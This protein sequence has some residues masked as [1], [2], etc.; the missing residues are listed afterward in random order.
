MLDG[1]QYILDKSIVVST[2]RP[3]DLLRSPDE[4]DS[5][6]EHHA[7]TFIPLGDVSDYVDRFAKKVAEGKTPKGMLVAP[8]GY[9]KTS[10]LIFLW[11]ACENHE[12][13]AVPPFFCTSLLDILEAAYAWS[14]YRL[15][16][17]QPGLVEAL[18]EVH[19]R[20]TG[21]TVEEMADRYSEEH[22]LAKITALNVLND[23]LA[24]GTLLLQLT[25]ANLLSFLDETLSIA[26]QADFKGLVLLPDEFQQY[27][28]KGADLRRSIQEFRE[29]V[30]GLATRREQL[31]VVFSVPSYTEGG[32]QSQGGD[33]LDRLRE[34]GFYYNLRDIYTRDFPARL[35]GRYAE[36]FEL[37]EAAEQVIDQHALAAV[38][39]IAE[40][41]D[42]GRGPRT[43]IDAF[44][45]AIVHWYDTQH[46]YTPVDLVDDFL[47][48]NIQFE[49]QASKL[50]T[51]T[52]QALA[53]QA[54]DAPQKQE[55]IKLMAAFPCGC[56]VDVQKAYG[57]YNATNELS[58]LAHGELMV[59]LIEG[60][61]LLGLQ[62]GEGPTHVVD[63]MTT[64]FWR[65]Y[66]VD[67]MHVEAAR[68]SFV[69][70]ALERLFPSRR[71][72][73]PLG[74][75]DL[76]FTP[77]PTGSQVALVEGNFGVRYPKRNVALQVAYQADQLQPDI[78]RADIQ[79]DFL[80]EWG[81]EQ[82]YNGAGLI[83]ELGDH[84]VRFYLTM[85]RKVGAS[86]PEDI[87]KL[88][89][90]VNP[91]YVTPLLMLGLVEY[92]DRW[93]EGEGNVIPDKD[94]AELDLLTNRLVGKSIE[95]L[96]NEGM[97]DALNPP[98][99]RVG[100]QMVE[101]VFNRKCH[102]LW[103]DYHTFYV[104]AHYQAVLDDYIT[105][106]RDMT[107]KQR[108]GNAPVEGDKSDL[109]RRFG[110]SSVA[111]FEN[112]ARSDYRDFMD[113]VAWEGSQ[114]TLL[115]KQHPLEESIFARLKASTQ[116]HVYERERVPALPA[117]EV[118]QLARALGYRDEETVYALQ[119]LAARG[120][121]RFDE[122][123]KA[124]CLV[125]TGPRPEDLKSA[126]DR[127]SD[128]LDAFPADMVE[129]ARLQ[130]F[131]DSLSAIGKR[132]TQA[133]APTEPSDEELDDLQTQIA[134]LDREVAEALNAGRGEW[135]DA[136]DNLL[137]DIDRA[138]IHLG[139]SDL[140]DRQITGQMDFVGH[141]NELRLSLVD[142]RKKLKQRYL[143]AKKELS[144]TQMEQDQDPVQ[145]TLS[146]HA[147]LLAGQT[148][149][150]Q[151]E[152]DR[153]RLDSQVALLGKWGTVLRD[154]D[155]LFNALGRLP[156]LR[157]ELTG[158][159]VPE[160][161]AN[162]TKHKLDALEDWEQFAAKMGA[163]EA[164]LEKRRRH[165]NETFGEAK[166]EYE[167]L[168]RTVEVE[169][170]RPRTRYTY[171]ED[172]ESYRD[173][174][175]EVKGKLAN[176]LGELQQE[177][178]RIKV[179]LLKARYIQ[180]L[181]EESAEIVRQVGETLAQTESQLQ[182]LHRALTLRLMQ[183][184]GRELADYCEQVERVAVSGGQLRQ[185]IGPVLFAHHDL[186]QEEEQTLEAF[187]PRDHV[188]LADLF[189]QLREAGRDID[190]DSL[191]TVLEQLYRKNRVIITVRRR[192]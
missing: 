80:F 138:L 89:D 54:V 56:P 51:V 149:Y 191:M 175:E 154:T 70:H 36:A 161:R 62:R 170:Y 41:E 145:S 177:L 83:E 103:P 60:Y 40:R 189:V 167:I 72:A 32:I 52:R 123:A 10:T 144:S 5:T 114:G 14:K 50:K 28:S 156:D 165:G 87:R 82:A 122:R 100:G 152:G 164:E 176:R 110:V 21:G 146:L 19:H 163:I 141:L 11:H 106:M 23:L 102:E 186:T 1:L 78:A 98:L 97:C 132:L 171:G 115:L 8:Y 160:I 88:Q 190:L 143:Q 119:L 53:S 180:A 38:G 178:D 130:G 48:S 96:F 92:F 37:G 150:T 46:S 86:M 15:Q 17:R 183:G 118:A 116:S 29:F 184:A 22:G 181:S 158:Q 166:E 111:T 25:P 139:Q 124:I 73:S 47:H 134:D 169:D 93:E 20:Y 43:V 162:F 12:V 79:F 4:V 34:D 187:G 85:R 63:V 95:L 76:E 151:L 173:L 18:D 77:S 33:I 81:E 67:E 133:L 3:D 64:D 31:G 192:G 125:A 140:L 42:L 26:L 44:K 7:T 142:A 59:H 65:D 109:A 128:T 16:Q 107:L 68:N 108:R 99:R 6:Y 57:L 148:T 127:L 104:K 179:D 185:A 135:R 45:C 61:T 101:E 39:E 90:F 117:D 2:V 120:Y 155:A 188:D 69:S 168:L 112:R 182:G 30:W 75:N 136:L 9:G 74:W 49:G 174:Y 121:T 113:V 153:A 147:K 129:P 105:S 13:L 58:K 35:W 137:V 172:Q 71:A 157:D 131:R 24:K 55:A 66:E 126:V 27:V 84:T 91:E 159:L 94:Q